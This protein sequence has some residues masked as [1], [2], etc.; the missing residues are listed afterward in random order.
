MRPEL[1]IW[2]LLTCILFGLDRTKVPLNV[3]EELS[4]LSPESLNYL[5]GRSNQSMVSGSLWARLHTEEFADALNLDV[6][7]YLE[8]FHELNRKRNT[9]FLNVLLE[10]IGALN[11]VEIVPMPIKGAAHLLSELYADRGERY[12]SDLDLLIPEE[13]MDRAVAAIQ[14]L[15]Y[16]EAVDSGFDYC[17]PQNPP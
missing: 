6:R 12:L 14:A 9:K 15:G 1:E 2:D 16:R 17:P 8:S 7:E 13:E 5:V 11:R 3:A 4:L 10:T